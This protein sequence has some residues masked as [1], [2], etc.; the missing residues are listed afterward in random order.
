MS[1]IGLDGARFLWFGNSQSTT[2]YSA[3]W[4]GQNAIDLLRAQGHTVSLLNRSVSGQTTTQILADVPAGV[5]AHHVLGANNVA[6]VQ[7][8]TNHLY[9]MDTSTPDRIARAAQEV[10]NVCQTLR[11]IGY[12]VIVIGSIFRDNGYPPGTT[13]PSLYTQD[14][15]AL[16]RLI[17]SQ[18]RQYA[19]LFWDVRLACPEY[20]AGSLVY[21]TDT[22]HQS[23]HGHQLMGSRF[24]T[25]LK[26][27]E[28][29]N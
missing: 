10:R 6:V 8:G 25:F 7:E 11:G 15:I 23:A 16:D 20:N 13:N 22:V 29:W 12:K 17:E 4:W 18:Y 19:D 27:Q 24:A 9:F 28:T 5:R 26:A 3:P 14:C 1:I 2:D 21:S